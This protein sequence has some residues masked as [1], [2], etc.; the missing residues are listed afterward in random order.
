MVWGSGPFNI[1]RGD[2]GF[3][4]YRSGVFVRGDRS[5]AHAIRKAEHEIRKASGRLGL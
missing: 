4:T 5:L 2:N 1:Y 3:Y